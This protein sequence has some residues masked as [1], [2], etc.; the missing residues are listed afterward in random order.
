[1][2]G[3]AEHHKIDASVQVD[4]HDVIEADA[5]SRQPACHLARTPH[6]AGVGQ[7]QI[8]ED[9]RHGIGTCPCRLD[10][11]ELAP[12]GAAHGRGGRR[13]TDECALVLRRDQACAGDRAMRGGRDR[14]QRPHV[15]I[16]NRRDAPV[17]RTRGVDVEEEG[18]RLRVTAANEAREQRETGL[19]ERGGLKD[20]DARRHRQAA[21][22]VVVHGVERRVE[23]LTR[24]AH[25]PISANGTAKVHFPS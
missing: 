8:V 18:E 13:P 4:R 14:L 20:A 3:Q 19:L 16:R 5:L 15:E 17:G 24:A 7:V 10:G 12:N 2:C 25:P 23:E 1:M 6:E 22:D 9:D 11:Q 21:V